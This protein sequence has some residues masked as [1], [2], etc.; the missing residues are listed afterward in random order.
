MKSL[1]LSPSKFPHNPEYIQH[2]C[3]GYEYF[4]TKGHPLIRLIQSLFQIAICRHG[5]QQKISPRWVLGMEQSPHCHSPK[6]PVGN[7]VFI[8]YMLIPRHISHNSRKSGN[9]CIYEMCCSKNVKLTYN[10]FS[11]FSDTTDPYT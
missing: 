9:I 10:V 2:I 1:S 8:I 7:V 6:T 5:P 11:L 4:Q 3:Q